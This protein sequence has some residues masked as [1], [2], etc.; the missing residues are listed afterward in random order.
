MFAPAAAA[1]RAAVALVT[2]GGLAACDGEPAGPGG[3]GVGGKGSGAAAPVTVTTARTDLGPI[4][5]DGEGR[6]L[7]VSTEDPPG[8]SACEGACLTTWPAVTGRATAGAALDPEL[9]GTVERA[10]GTVQVSYADHPLYRHRGD[11]APGDLTG[12]GTDGTWWV[13]GPD[14][15]AVMNSP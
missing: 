14:G 2:L 10:D 1:L 15:E 11:D 6:T 7:Y 13:V 5:V 4:L 3:Y 12:Q 9:L 8:R